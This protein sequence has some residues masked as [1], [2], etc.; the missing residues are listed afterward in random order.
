MLAFL[1]GTGPEGRGLAL[2]LAVSG[3]DVI[4]GSRDAQRAADAAVELAA[5]VE[6]VA[7]CGRI[8]GADNLE[9]ATRADAAFLT[10]PYEA[11]AP[12]LAPLAE[13]LVG[14]VV[15]NVIAPMRFERGRGAIAVPVEA[16][17]AAEEAQGL[18]PDSRI[19]AAFQ[20]VSAEELQELG[21]EMEGDVVICS[22][23]AEA[24]ELV[25]S[26]TSKIASLRPVDGGGLGNSRYV[27]QITP[28]LVNIN[29]IYKVHSGIKIVGVQE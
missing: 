14:K 25:K 28:L 12:M 9:A 6:G 3:E 5:L 4:I 8:E 2:R 18:L 22:D 27:E 21:H 23:H 7:G 10:V 11:Q 17:S 26:Y 13:P 29:R 16:G 19:V 1:G 20:N 24:K 15:V